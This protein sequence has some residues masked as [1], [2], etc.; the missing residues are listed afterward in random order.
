MDS[1]EYFLH[2]LRKTKYMSPHLHV[3]DHKISLSTESVTINFHWLTCFGAYQ[4]QTGSPRLPS[5]AWRSTPVF[6]WRTVLCAADM[7]VGERSSPVV[8]L[9][10]AGCPTVTPRYC[11]CP[12][13][14]HSCMSQDL[15]R[16]FW[17]FHVCHIFLYWHFG[18]NCKRI[19]FD[20]ILWLSL[21]IAIVNLAVSVT[22]AATNIM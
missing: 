7:P 14:C 8:D 2:L 1:C 11:C 5:S 13:I 6:R 20:I 16:S 17:R 19:Y 22:W 18:D 4:V 12:F 9:Q 21:S 3:K 10:S 15:E